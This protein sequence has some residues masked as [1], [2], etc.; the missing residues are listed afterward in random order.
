MAQSATEDLVENLTKQTQNKFYSLKKFIHRLTIAELA[1]PPSDAAS[2]LIFKARVRHLL[3]I[4]AIDEA[5]SLLRK[6]D[7]LTPASFMLWFETQLFREDPISACA[8]L[9]SKSEISTDIAT[10]IYCHAINQDWF[11][12]ELLLASA[13]SLGQLEE[14]TAKLLT[15]FLEPDLIDESDLPVPSSTSVLEL[16]MADALGLPFKLSEVPLGFLHRNLSENAGRQTRI[17]TAERLAK[18]GAVAP[19]YLQEVYSEGRASA[20][21]ALWNRV[22][23]ANALKKVTASNDVDIICRNFLSGWR[24]FGDA[25]LLSVFSRIFAEDLSHS[26]FLSEECKNHQI[27]LILLHPKRNSL[28]FDLLSEISQEDLLYALSTDDF[29]KTKTSNQIEEAIAKGMQATGDESLIGGGALLSQLFSL[30]NGLESDPRN[31]E[32][33]LIALRINGL[34]EVATDLAFEIVILNRFN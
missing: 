18:S 12:A 20:S 1:G 30:S 11:A 9:R 19:R 26:A 34:A 10:S 32:K 2:G 31:I 7:F 3:N 6:A 21:G 27:D 13:I 8:P 22:A 15:I 24:H 17:R 33:S 23:S 5:D 14:R 28:L 4:G 16:V 25:G 29:G